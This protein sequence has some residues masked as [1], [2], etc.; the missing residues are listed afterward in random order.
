MMSSISK[1]TKKQEYKSCFRRKLL[2]KHITSQL[3]DLDLICPYI[4][5]VE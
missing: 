4:D 3:E 2:K 5:L 1:P